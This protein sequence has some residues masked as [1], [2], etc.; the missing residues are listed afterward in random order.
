M[1]EAVH[2]VLSTLP[3]QS[4]LEQHGQIIARKWLHIHKLNGP[5]RARSDLQA[6]QRGAAGNLIGSVRSEDADVIEAGLADE[7]VEN[8]E[9]YV[10]GPVKIVEDQDEWFLVGDSLEHLRHG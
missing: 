3:R 1:M 9:R 4:V 6:L 2:Q 5:T 10:I 8:L 7:E